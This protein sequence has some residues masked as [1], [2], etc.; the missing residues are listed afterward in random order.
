M[1]S[2][3]D[4]WPGWPP[5][6][7]ETKMQKRRK[8]SLVRKAKSGWS[9]RRKLKLNDIKRNLWRRNRSYTLL[10]AEPTA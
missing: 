1:G 3:N 5:D 2:I 9:P 10:I 8:I 7:E 4:P 6:W